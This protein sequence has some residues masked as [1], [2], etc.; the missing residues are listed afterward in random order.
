MSDAEARFHLLTDV[1]APSC[2]PL[3]PV[4]PSRESRTEYEGLDPPSGHSVVT[5]PSLQRN[6]AGTGCPTSPAVKTSS[7]CLPPRGA[8]RAVGGIRAGVENSGRRASAT[9]DTT[10]IPTIRPKIPTIR[11]NGHASPP[12]ATLTADRGLQRSEQEPAINSATSCHPVVLD[13]HPRWLLGALGAL[14][15][16]LAK[17]RR[18]S[19]ARPGFA[20][21]GCGHMRSAANAAETCMHPTTQIVRGRLRDALCAD[22]A[23]QPLPSA[24]MTPPTRSEP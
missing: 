17:R 8:D 16:L 4:R 5:E 18:S 13:L 14:T 23:S 12:C 2:S 9:N 1:I 7:P 20:A 21:R 15:V 10:P 11:R 22:R 6:S 24:P 3:K 19:C